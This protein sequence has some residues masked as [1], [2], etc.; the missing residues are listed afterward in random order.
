MD[1]AKIYESISLRSFSSIDLKAH[2]FVIPTYIKNLSL[3]FI[4]IHN[5]THNNNNDENH[6]FLSISLLFYFIY[7]TTELYKHNKNSKFSSN[8][9]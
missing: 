5:G 6:Y 2:K 9:S 8:Y 7:F 1:V 3:Y 4:K